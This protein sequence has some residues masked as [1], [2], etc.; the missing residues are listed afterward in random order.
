MRLIR[1][2]N[3][4]VVQGSR[5][6]MFGESC[7]PAVQARAKRALSTNVIHGEAIHPTLGPLQ[8]RMECRQQLQPAQRG[9]TVNLTALLL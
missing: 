8:T 1:H 7:V 9:A 5:R 3:Q 6:G 2:P 4:I